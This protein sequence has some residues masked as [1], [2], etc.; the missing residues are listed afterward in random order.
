MSVASWKKSAATV[1]LMAAALLAATVVAP[2]TA[3]NRLQAQTQT[4]PQ[5]TTTKAKSTAK[6]KD[7]AAAK[8][9]ID[10]NTATAEEMVDT[11]PG[12]GEARAKAIVENRPYLSIND[13]SKAKIPAAE[14]ERIRP[15]VTVST[16][17]EAPK[18]KTKGR[19]KAETPAEKET[20]KAKE[21]TAA[22]AAAAAPSGKVDLN[23]AS[24]AE[25][26]TLP[27]IGPALA[28]E[29]RAARPIRSIDDLDKIKGM[30]PAKLDGLRDYVSFGAPA[31]PATTPAASAAA[32]RETTAAKTAATAAKVDLNAAS[33]SQIES[34]P[35]VGP[36]IAR[37]IVAARPIRSFEDLDKVKNMGKAKVDG[38][39]DLV[40]F[41][42]VA[43]SPAPKEVAAKRETPPPAKA[44]TKAATTKPAAAKAA[45]PAPGGLVNI[46]TATA[47]QL[48]SLFGIGE[49][50]AEAIIEARPFKTKED[51]MKVKGIKEGVYAKIKD[52]ITV[53]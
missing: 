19:T 14:I 11:L 17:A 38:L 1:P 47:E 32:R 6:A 33:L 43:E 21:K 10:L 27:G 40:S 50:K 52:R 13:L 26:E 12:I 41:G 44:A 53:E 37:E 15:L 7:K 22:K 2:E 23:T 8:T 9:L 31:E 25:L 49:V 3:A 24:A 45:T 48:D 4:P 18:A 36:V 29:I 30:G 42:A 39:R 34:L 5:T 51:I 46:N 16:A 28:R 35:G 20:A